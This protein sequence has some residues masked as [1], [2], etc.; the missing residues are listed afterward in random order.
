VI[1]AQMI[2]ETFLRES[3]HT[4]RTW[5]LVV[6]E[7]HEFVGENFATIITDARSYNVF[8]VVAHQDRS[9][10][11][12]L[13]TRTLKSAVG[14]AGVK[15]L[16]ATSPEDR[17]AYASLYGRDQADLVLGLDRYRAMVSIMDGLV[18]T[19]QSEQIVLDDWWGAPI[20]GQLATLQ[21]SA[22][23]LTL[24]KRE[25]VQ[26]NNQRYWDRL[27]AASAGGRAGD[28]REQ[29]RSNQ[30]R[31]S[32]SHAKHPK[33]HDPPGP[34]ASQPGAGQAPPPGDDSPRP[35]DADGARPASL[36]DDP[37]DF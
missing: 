2:T 9:Q 28:Q 19:R 23:S 27:D 30:R 33:P 34:G 6:D 24:P 7:F 13:A 36:L 26:R 15:V 1:M 18:G 14:H 12:R 10:L 16:M 11:D 31:T 20:D 17:V 25:V 37:P 8:P 5:R 32:R 4:S 22:H 35:A 3:Q 29:P 21:Q